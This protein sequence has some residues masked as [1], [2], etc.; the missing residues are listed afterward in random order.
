MSNGRFFNPSPF[1]H[2]EQ[3]KSWIN[4]IE[5]LINQKLP[6]ADLRIENVLTNSLFLDHINLTF[7]K[8][9]GGMRL[10]FKDRKNYKCCA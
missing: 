5:G 4:E 7:Y 1:T 6:Q 3:G 10:I 8:Q 2:G 9:H